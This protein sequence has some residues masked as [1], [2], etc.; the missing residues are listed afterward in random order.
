MENI[1]AITK[2]FIERS[3]GIIAL[4][5]EPTDW[6]GKGF[7]CFDDGGV[8]L[9]VGEFL[10]GLVRVMKPEYILETGTYT[11]ISAMY[12]AQ[13]LTDNDLGYLETIEFEA[14][15]KARAEMLWRNV[16]VMSRVKCVFIDAR[17]FKPERM[18]DLMFLDSEPDMRFDELVRFF[19]HLKPG[20][21]V[22]IH[23]LH[24]HMSQQPH[25]MFFGWPYGKLPQQIIDWVK[26]DELRPIHFPTPRGFMGFY[27]P[28]PN[29]FRWR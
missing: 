3:N 25:E 11:G 22:F 6:T 19:D 13:G 21:F 23:D 18:Y 28:A 8:E 20:G 14:T 12:M 24:P 17:K 7:R 26:D 16:G 5:P 15:H 9:E 29:D 4:Q 2:N 27:K 10:Y 1:S